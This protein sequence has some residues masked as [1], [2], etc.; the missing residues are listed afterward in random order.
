MDRNKFETDAVNALTRLVGNIGPDDEIGVALS[1]GADSVALLSALNGAGVRVEALHCNFHLR[2]ADSD[3]D[4]EF[5]RRLCSDLNVPLT[6]VDFD[7][8][9]CQERG[10]SVEMTCRRLRYDWFE[11]QAALRGLK[12][13]AIAHHADD[14]VETVMLNLFRGTGLKGLGGIPSRRGIYVRPLLQ[15]T[16]NQILEYLAECGLGYRTDASNLQNDYRRNAV[17]NVILPEAERYFPDARKGV[18]TTSANMASS[19]ALLD[20]FVHERAFSCFDNAKGLDIVRLLG[21]TSKPVEMLY[22]G[23]AAVFPPGV[24]ATVARDI[25]DAVN[26]S[27]GHFMLADGTRLVLS[28]GMLQKAVEQASDGCVLNDFTDAAS[29]PIAVRISIMDKAGFAAAAKNNSTLFLDA[30]IL[31]KPR[32]FEVRQ[33]RSGDRLKPFGMK[34]SRLVSDIISDAKLDARRKAETMVLTCDGELLWVIGLRASRNYQVT[35][36]AQRVIVVELLS[37]RLLLK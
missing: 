19:L 25:L 3:G 9:S 26:T 20:E 15:F 12:A 7:T 21:A 4:A 5:C 29:W 16:R 27:G 18:L 2:G 31:D 33:W 34:G 11:R 13:V 22:R 37:N 30:A 23:V 24:N 6:A 28:R 35:Q 8:L 36:S 10:E 32:R 14:D 17:R 1:G